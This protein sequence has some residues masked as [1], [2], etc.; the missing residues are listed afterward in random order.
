VVKPIEFSSFFKMI[1]SV[2]SGE[3]DNLENL[4]ILL[5]DYEQG[6]DSDSML[7]ELGQKFCTVGINELLRFTGVDNIEKISLMKE[8]EWDK[9]QEE[10]RI[11]IPNHLANS[12]TK[13]AREVNLPK[14][15][16]EKW[17]V[18]KRE[19]SKNLQGMS[20]YIT[21]GILDAID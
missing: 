20:R 4:N 17:D 16:S 14:V 19:V 12:M 1:H 10:K 9:L 2:S 21:E 5:A 15:L 18:P 6:T 3:S 13:Y 11:T 7:Y 8:E